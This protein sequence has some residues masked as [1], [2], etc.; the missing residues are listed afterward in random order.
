MVPTAQPARA[1]APPDGTPAGAP[2]AT[3][4]RALV[5]HEE[6]NVANL[7]GPGARGDA[8]RGTVEGREGDEHVVLVDDIPANHKFARR[9]IAAG[10]E[11]L[12]YGLSIGRA[13]TAIR[14][15][16]HVHTHNIESNR[17]RGDLPH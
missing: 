11:I 6:D 17:G 2:A 1:S 9:D 16:E 14:R 15:G 13:S 5:V 12:K 3:Q 8:V 10:E 7:I 4:R